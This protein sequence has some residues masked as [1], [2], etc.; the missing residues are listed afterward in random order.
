MSKR[1]SC[2][3][4]NSLNRNSYESFLHTEWSPAD[5][6]AF[7]LRQGQAWCIM[8]MTVMYNGVQYAPVSC[9]QSITLPHS[10][11]VL[12]S[13]VG[14]FGQQALWMG[15]V[16]G[17]PIFTQLLVCSAQKLSKQAQR[18]SFASRL[19]RS[20][21]YSARWLLCLLHCNQPSAE[22]FQAT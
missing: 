13:V 8:A 11:D 1:F 18:S 17:Q 10:T 3:R 22:P 19:V 16:E 15:S 4:N 6:R 5:V 14:K 9:R 7:L 21:H 20:S 12:W 2:S